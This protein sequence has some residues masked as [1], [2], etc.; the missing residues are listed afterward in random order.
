M[1][2]VASYVVKVD[3]ILVYRKVTLNLVIEIKGPS[4]DVERASVEVA[5]ASKEF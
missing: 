3:K 2:E 1:V 5:P 4:R